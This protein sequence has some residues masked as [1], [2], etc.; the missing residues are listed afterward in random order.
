MNSWWISLLYPVV[1]ALGLPVLVGVLIQDPATEWNLWQAVQDGFTKLTRMGRDS[2]L[3][4]LQTLV[5]VAVAATIT[6]ESTIRR[7]QAVARLYR[8]QGQYADALLGRELRLLDR[9][10]GAE[11]MVCNLFVSACF[12][13]TISY[14]WF[15][16]EGS[17][18]SGLVSVSLGAW[19]L[20]QMR[21]V[22]YA[23]AF[24]HDVVQADRAQVER[25]VEQA[26][27]PRPVE[28]V[29]GARGALLLILVLT[30]AMSVIALLPGGVPAALL[31]LT[32]L[33]WAGVAHLLRDAVVEY[34]FQQRLSC[35]MGI[36][37]A[38]ALSNVAVI[39]TGLVSARL[40]PNDLTLFVIYLGAHTVMFVLL[41]LGFS[42]YGPAKA[43]HVMTLLA[44]EKRLI[45]ARRSRRAIA[46]LLD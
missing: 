23:T 32:V 12:L 33:V 11:L 37:L 20:I 36:S 29:V 31:V 16:G 7:G 45:A 2:Q 4:L 5:G 13:L 21:K 26:V 18:L 28:R 40:G 41:V 19:I 46:V 43:L 8:D 14:W 1:V 10:S 24:A 3:G 44:A 30:S 6:L 34:L 22:R 25:A 27:Y 15:G 9:V 39:F 38:F 17:A 42:G 35:W